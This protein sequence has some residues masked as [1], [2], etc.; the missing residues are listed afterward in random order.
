MRIIGLMSGT[1]LDGID[2]AAIDVERHGDGLDISLL[3]HATTPY[4]AELRAAL[5]AA[6][7]P[8]QGS[9]RDVCALNARIAEAFADAVSRLCTRAGIDLASVDAIGSHGQTLYH[10]TSGRPET[11]ATLQVGSPAIIAQLTGVTAVGDF[12]VADVAAGGEGAPL[13]PF[14]DYL[15]LRSDNEHRVALNIGGIANVTWLPAG[16]GP[17]EVRAFDTGPGNML[18]D[19]CMRFE[20][21]GVHRYDRGGALAQSGRVSQALVDELMEE[22]WFRRPSPKSTGREEFGEAYAGDVLQRAANLGVTGPNLIASVTAL[23]AHTIAA[24]VPRECDRMIVSGGGVH[25]RALMT[26]LQDELDKRSVRAVIERSDA[27]GM[28][29]DAKEAMVFAVLAH[30]TLHGRANNLPSATGARSG[31]IMGLIAPGKN[32]L[33]LMRALWAQP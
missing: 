32:F 3:G 5:E 31:V 33:A 9:T 17:E 11:R 15:L 18:I 21:H 12:R 20:S 28:P 14:V 6:L 30:E 4:S 23:T 1:S 2:A 29:V 10:M 8:K 27:F 25:N 22:P 13:V 26:M 24:A 19:A 7:P 16:C